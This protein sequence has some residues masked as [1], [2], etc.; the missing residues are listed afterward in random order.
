LFLK[1]AYDSSKI[2]ALAGSE[3]KS[4]RYYRTWQGADLEALLKKQVEGDNVRVISGDVLSGRN[5][6]KCQYLGYSD[7]LVSVIPEGDYY[8]A[9]GWAMPGFKKFSTSRSFF[10]WMGSGKKEYVL[11]SNF[12]GEER[13][14]VVSEEYEKVLPMDILPVYLL[15]AILANDIDKMEQ[16][17]IYEVIEEDLALCEY[18]CTSKIKVQ[19]V[20]RKGINS[21]IKELG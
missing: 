15:K 16:L 2:I 12:H 6:T 7:S 5:I 10:S 19:D 18:V 9:F 13:A 8:E 1:G 20:L 4:P 21:M 14:F 3:V 11:D 17:G